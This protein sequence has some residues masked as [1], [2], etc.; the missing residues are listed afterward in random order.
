MWLVSVAQLL[1]LVT[2]SPE[3]A[4]GW[5]RS[6]AGLPK[7]IAT[8]QT[9]FSIPFQITQSADPR[10]QAAEVQLFVSANRGGRWD[11]YS[12]VEPSRRHFLFHAGGDGEYWFLIR[13]VNLH[14]QLSP[15]ATP[16]PGLVVVVDTKQPELRI[17]ARRGDAG[18]VVAHWQLTEPHLAPDS[19]QIQYRT[20]ADQPWQSVAFERTGLQGNGATQSGEVSWWPNLKTGRVEIRAEAADTAGNIA[21]THAQ[22]NFDSGPVATTNPAG[23]PVPLPLQAQSPPQPPDPS[24]T[25]WRHSSPAASPASSSV[26]SLIN[27]PVRNQF[28]PVAQPSTSP[29][30]PPPPPSQPNNNR[31]RMVNSRM[32]EIRYTVNLPNPTAAAKVE[33]WGTLDGGKTWSSFGVDDDGRSPMVVSVK[34]EGIYGFRIVLPAPNDGGNQAPQPGETPQFWIG[35]DL[36]KPQAQLLAAEPTTS[37]GNTDQML[38]R[39]QADDRM[40]AAKPI[41]LLFS[42][43]PGG[44]WMPIATNLANTGQY[45][46]PLN[47]QLPSQLYLRLEV[48]DE[49][50]N[51]TIHQTS[52]PVALAPAAVQ[53]HDVTPIPDQA[54][55]QPKVYYFR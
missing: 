8:R 26:T 5:D 41:S 47:R 11:L 7:P 55:T 37:G 14:G 24:S 2:P 13:T 4:T 12:R 20:A 15:Q 1:M 45:V 38:I 28:I 16:H 19:F 40:L 3:P 44:P 36:T 22:V 33:L 50:G 18:Q 34:Q 29:N 51:L 52:H 48:R 23:P 10:Q 25:R 6:G 35:V 42:D 32:F 43:S 30:Q 21:V 54:R 53:L 46:W 49:A 9:V 27:P 39:W 17:D 31:P